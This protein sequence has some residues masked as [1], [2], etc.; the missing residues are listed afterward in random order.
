MDDL[1]VVLVEGRLTRDP[2]LKYTPSGMAVVNFSVAVSR[3]RKVDGEQVKEASFF[4]VVAWA[5]LAEACGQ[6]LKKGRGVRV[7]GQLKQDRWTS[8]EGDQRSKVVVVADTVAFK[9]E[10]RPDAGREPGEG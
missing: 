8:P 10:P 6:Y 9:P 7:Q 2:E 1:N 3:S 5:K 4:D